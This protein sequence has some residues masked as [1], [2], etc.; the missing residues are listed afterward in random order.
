M[1]DVYRKNAF[2]TRACPTRRSSCN[3]ATQRRGHDGQLKQGEQEV[4]H[5]R[6]SVGQTS[7]AT[8]RGL[9][10]GF[11][12][13]I[14]N[15]RHTGA[16]SAFSTSR[17]PEPRSVP[18]FGSSV[19]TEKPSHRLEGEHRDH[20]AD[21]SAEAV[22]GPV[23]IR[24]TTPPGA[25]QR[26]RRLHYILY[27]SAISGVKKVRI[28]RRRCRNRPVQYS[29]NIL[30]QDHQAI[31]RRVT[32]KQGFRAFAARRTIRGYEATH[33]IRKGQARWVSGSNVRRQIQF[34]NKLF[35]VAA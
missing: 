18:G 16:G 21:S 17:S 25:S 9:N 32:A 5:A 14:G 10:P 23:T 33:M 29:N 20:P 34:I 1:I 2:S 24:A 35:V 26:G 27:I 30:E 6:D 12:E 22:C 11:S 7:G 28:L 31:K 4:L 19:L 3:N 15:S 8:P 13:R